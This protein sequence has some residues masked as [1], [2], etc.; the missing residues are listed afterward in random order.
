MK[1]TTEFT[2]FAGLA[3]LIH[4]ALFA[5]AP[6]TGA[7]SSGAGGEAL[8]SLQPASAEVARMAEAWQKPPE[9]PQIETQKAEPLPQV[10][11][12]ALP[13]IDLAQAP[14]AALLAPLAQPAAA[15]PVQVD[16]APA[17]PPKPRKPAPKP[18][19]QA[20]PQQTPPPKAN[21]NRNAAG[22]A[23]QRAAGAG[24]GA[25]AGQSGGARTATADP[26]REAKLRTVWGNKI[27]ARIE[28][29]KRYPSGA[30]GRAQV[31][32]R[33]T[34]ARDGR[35]LDHRIAKSSGI[36]AFDQAALDA[37]ARAGKFPP[38]PKKL[39]AVQIR[40]SLPVSFTK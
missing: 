9:A 28:R 40:L 12:P 5:S 3:G 19:P 27:R 16:T 33:L 36:A 14:R 1:R 37:V 26:G 15:Q 32:L 6:E 35:L 11:A 31:V 24:G 18:E 22:Q 8:V 17:P 21:S 2:V 30:R 4:I 25:E 38:A 23:G 13:Q 10:Q 7:Q 34:V 29:R 39:Q 20:K